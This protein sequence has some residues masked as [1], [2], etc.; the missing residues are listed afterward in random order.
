[1][2]FLSRPTLTLT[3]SRHEAASPC[4]HQT[5]I[6]AA[7]PASPEQGHKDQHSHIYGQD[8]KAHTQGMK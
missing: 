1:M 2:A 7:L 5:E 6:C 3:F 4:K 8:I